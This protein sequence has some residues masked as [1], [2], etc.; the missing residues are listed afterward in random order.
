MRGF[1]NAAQMAAVVKTSH[2]GKESE[3]GTQTDLQI[4][5]ATEQR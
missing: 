3:L 5:S 4:T 1:A 2:C